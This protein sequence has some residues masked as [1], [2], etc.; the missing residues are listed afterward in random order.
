MY[1]R[2]IDFDRM[3][4]QQ[5]RDEFKKFNGII[6]TDLVN[7]LSR[8]I[9]FASEKSKPMFSKNL[10]ALYAK[11]T[12]QTSLTDTPFLPL[13]E[14]TKG[15][16]MLGKLVQGNKEFGD[17]CLPIS[18]LVHSIAL[19]GTGT[20]KSTLVWSILKQLIEK[21]SRLLVFDRK[22]DIRNITAS[23][24]MAILNANDLRIN[25]FDPPTSNINPRAWISK[26]CDLFTIFGLYYSSRNYIKE[27][28]ITLLEDTRQTPT[29]FDVYY[30]IKSKA[31]RGQTRANYHD[32]SLN[33]IQNIVEELGP[34][35]SCKKSFPLEQLLDVPIA[36]EVDQLSM[37]SERFLV[38]FFLLAI[39]EMRKAK[40]IRGNPAIDEESI[41]IFVDEAANLWNPQLDNSD[42]VQ[43]MS[44]DIL[45]EIPL[46]ARDFKI[47]LFFSSQRPL[48]KNIMANVR[49]K[50]LSNMPDAEDAWYMANSIGTKPD[51]FQKLGVGEF[52]V[53][54]GK[55]DPFLIRTE[56]MERQILDDK[57]FDEMKKPF[58][59]HI[60]LNCTP[61]TEQI[62]IEKIDDT[63]RLSNDSKK[64]LI[65]VTNYP[66]LTVTQRY[67]ELSLKGRYAQDLKQSLIDRKLIEEIFLAIG[68]SKQSTYL[69]PTQKAIDYLDSIGESTRFYKHIGKTSPLHQLIQAM[70]I[71]YFTDKNCV[72]QNDYQIGEKF[73]DVYI[74]SD[75]KKIALEVAVNPAIDAERV[76]SALDFV[77]QFVILPVDLMILKSIENSL[78]SLKSEKIKIFLASF[79]LASMKKGTL[80]I[81]PQN[82]L[83]QQN[84]QNKQNLAS[85]EVEQQ[86]NRSNNQLG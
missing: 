25:I 14:N 16:I 83:E 5:I 31:E 8:G 15:D 81:I 77:D 4:P 62:T 82:T 58:A 3:N 52:L 54:T 23:V 79:F 84:N 28:V 72:V 26:V 57:T 17:Y 2:N 75:K 10:N 76:L 65:N 86:K 49:T 45:Q 13:P 30:S 73:V 74:E 67:D 39:I 11:A 46:I 1:A 19:G 60:M 51:I 21:K 70:L 32:A 55:T 63:S 44:F 80:A 43:E 7:K 41:F 18:E 27:F 47:C 53:K 85:D 34:C 59:E 66:S 20:G 50:L 78:K 9:A 64:F 42:R 33:K 71:E 68:S 56:K 12:L 29:I 61:L 35:F 36:I 22:R 24:P 37:Q 69:V 6:K 40:S 48:S 38:A